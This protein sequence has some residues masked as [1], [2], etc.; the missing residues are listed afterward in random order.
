MQDTPPKPRN[1]KKTG[2]ILKEFRNSIISAYPTKNKF[3]MMVSFGLEENL[4]SIAGG[5]NLREVV[6]ELIGW[7]IEQGRLRELVEAAREHNSRNRELQ[8]I[9]KDMNW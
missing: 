4:D 3:K 9:S 8:R 2:Q 1:T 5:D 6:F 7:A